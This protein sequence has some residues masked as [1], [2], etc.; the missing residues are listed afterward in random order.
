MKTIMNWKGC[1]EYREKLCTVLKTSFEGLKLMDE[2]VG[3]DKDKNMT[4]I[5]IEYVYMGMTHRISIMREGINEPSYFEVMR[6]IQQKE[7][8]KIKN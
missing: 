7:V 8:N 1:L 6:D 5:Y 3:F 2:G 4:E